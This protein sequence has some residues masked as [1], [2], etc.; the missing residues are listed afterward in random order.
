MLVTIGI[1][2]FLGP[3]VVTIGGNAHDRVAVSVTGP[4]IAPAGVITVA[5]VVTPVVEVSDE[6][7]LLGLGHLAV[8][9]VEDQGHIARAGCAVLVRVH[10]VLGQGQG[11]GAIAGVVQYL[12][13]QGLV[14]HGVGLVVRLVLQLRPAGIVW[15]GPGLE[16]CQSGRGKEDSRM[17][18]GDGEQPHEDRIGRGLAQLVGDGELEG[19][20]A[21]RVGREGDDGLGADDAALGRIEGRGKDAPFVRER[22]VV[23]AGPIV[24]A[25]PVQSDGGAVPL[26]VLLVGAR[27]RKGRVGVVDHGE[28]GTKRGITSILAGPEMP[29]VGVLLRPAR[30]ISQG[31]AVVGLFAP[32]PGL[33]QRSHIPG[34]PAG[35]SHIRVA[36]FGRGVI[37]ARFHPPRSPGDVDAFAGVV[38]KG[39]VAGDAMFARCVDGGIHLIALIPVL[40][41]L[42]ELDAA[43]GRRGAGTRIAGVGGVVKLQGG[44]NDVTV[45]GDA[46]EVET[47]QGIVS[48]IPFQG[49]NFVQAVVFA[50]LRW[51][52]PIVAADPG[53]FHARI[54]IQPLLED[55]GLF[56]S[57]SSVDCNHTTNKYCDLSD[58]E[59]D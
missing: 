3:S 42:I 15:R 41:H 50:V 18:R 4:V 47:Q 6:V 49:Q 55:R 48:A 51:I 25:R 43:H 46:A 30:R 35:I 1:Q 57:G 44:G 59:C 19:P 5:G 39:I 52:V 45:G 26:Q 53:V 11:I 56:A 33:H 8:T 2:P 17:A 36:G 20:L 24:A 37:H 23:A 38:V 28:L 9:P 40:Q 7:V 10:L 16:V 27:I 31:E 32:H 54:A 58:Q 22:G 12:G 14:Q 29:P 21:G 13:D 34:I